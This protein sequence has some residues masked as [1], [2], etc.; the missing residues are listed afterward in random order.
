MEQQRYQ[1]AAEKLRSKFGEDMTAF[2]A[3]KDGVQYTRKMAMVKQKALV[4]AARRKFLV[5]APKRPLAALGLFVERKKK[6]LENSD[7]GSLFGAKLT[8]HIGKLWASLTEADRKPFEEEAARLLQ[9]FHAAT[10]KFQEGDTYQELKAAEARAAEAA[11]KARGR[12]KAKGKGKGKAKAKAKAKAK[13]KASSLV[14]RPGSMPEKPPDAYRLW[15]RQKQ[16][17]GESATRALYAGLGEDEKKRLDAEVAKLHA[18]YTQDLAAFLKSKDGKAY[19]RKLESVG[20]KQKL[21]RAKAQ[22]REAAPPKPPGAFKL[23]ATAQKGSGGG[24]PAILWSK[25]SQDERK[26]WEGEQEKKLAEWEK[27]M[28][29]FRKSSDYKKFER[30]AKAKAKSGGRSKAPAMEGA[31][32]KPPNAFLFFMK[33]QKGS[34]ASLEAS[35]KKWAELGAEGQ[36]KYVDQAMAAAVAHKEEVKVWLKTSAGKKHVQAQTRQQKKKTEQKAK[37]KYLKAPDAPEP[38]EK[39]KNAKMLFLEERRKQ[40]LKDEPQ[41]PPRD[42]AKRLLQEWESLSADA[43][44]VWDGKERSLKDVYEFELEEYKNSE[45]YKRFAKATEARGSGKGSGR[46]R[47]GRSGN[48][49]RKKGKLGDLSFDESDEMGS[50]SDSD[51]LDISD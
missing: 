38:P 8:A 22:L 29:E 35:R 24:R 23:F 27:A 1:E 12:G 40:L 51:D 2:L 20:R 17:Q 45:A 7:D 31:P 11:E 37:D 19:T 49:K 36:K 44:K 21:D 16:A 3:S 10:K 6:E 33:E 34:I 46:G 5:D 13:P 50:A 42:M 47:G 43:K 28:Q 14:A 25:L 30:V 32:K 39:P 48:K 41:L 4:R 26:H 18:K 9:D 15:C